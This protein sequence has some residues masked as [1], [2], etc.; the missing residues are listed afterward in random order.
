MVIAII[1]ILA[2][3]LLPALARAK[4]AG[5]NA[6]CK[7]NLRQIGIALT[8]YVG[9]FQKYPLFAEIVPDFSAV[10]A[11]DNKLV[12][13]AAKAAAVFNCPSNKGVPQWTNN[14]PTMESL[15]VGFPN[16]SYGYN[17]SGCAHFVGPHSLGLGGSWIDATSTAP[18]YVAEG[19][20]DS[21]SDMI[22]IADYQPQ[23]DPDG[24]FD[25]VNLL[26]DLP[27]PRHRQ[28]AN[29]VFGDVHIEFAKQ[30]TWLER[31][32][33]R[34]RRWNIDHEPHRELWNP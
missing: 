24:D 25:P 33:T 8:L 20:V 31:N 14:S 21:P 17:L 29:V 28:G 1:A 13:F 23:S 5:R 6:A 11:W 10:S 27:S 19:S 3:L 9:D 15:T 18:R 12:P 16:P 22:S 30:T 7:S 2:A 34:R 26:A 4:E 32:D